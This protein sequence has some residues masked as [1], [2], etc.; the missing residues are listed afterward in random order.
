MATGMA[1]AVPEGVPPSEE[2]LP[3]DPVGVDTVGGTGGL[4]LL[5]LRCLEAGP[6]PAWRERALCGMAAAEQWP[7]SE[8]LSLSE[9]ESP[10]ELRGRNWYVTSV[11][12]GQN[13]PMM[14]L[15]KVSI[16]RQ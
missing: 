2:P 5:P 1:R 3:T 4:R 14:R 8:V 16:K 12:F 9:S 13:R 7:S 10:A 6:K 11:S 15:G